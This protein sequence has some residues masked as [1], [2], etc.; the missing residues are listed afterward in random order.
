MEKINCEYCNKLITKIQ[1]K[2][3]KNSKLCR[4]KQLNKDIILPLKEYKCKYC[5]KSF[6]RLDDKNE[7]EN[8][9]SCNSKELLLIIKEK[10]KGRLHNIGSHEF[11]SVPFPQRF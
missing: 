1:L 9:V 8:N 7:H 4:N 2:R 5:N 10:E 3:H 6:N 11:Q